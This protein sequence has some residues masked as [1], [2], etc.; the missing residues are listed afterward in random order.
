MTALL[1]LS[2]GYALNQPP[3]VAKAKA[4]AER[5]TALLA[6]LRT[7]P[8]QPGYTETEWKDYLKR[9]DESVGPW[10]EYVKALE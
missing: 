8:P 3:N 2:R 7:K 1:S 5:A 9:N 4:F 10:A 6:E